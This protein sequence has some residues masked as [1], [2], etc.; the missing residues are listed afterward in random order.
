M[1]NTVAIVSLSAGT[2]GEKFVEHE[3]SLGVKRLEDYGLKV[4]MMPHARNGIGYVKKNPDKRAEDLISAFND[5][6]VDMILCAIG[7]DD[8]YRLLP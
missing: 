8:T 3:V 1:V 2:I 4:K 7:G 5:P 6:D